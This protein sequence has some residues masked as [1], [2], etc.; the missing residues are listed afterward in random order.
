MTDNRMR[1]MN[2]TEC[3]DE[4][5]IGD[6]DPRL[7]DLLLKMDEIV[8]MR[9]AEAIEHMIDTTMRT[10]LEVEAVQIVQTIIPVVEIQ[11]EQEDDAGERRREM[12]S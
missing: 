4:T 7:A 1:K 3:E 10:H 11:E 9:K 6:V 5:R 8:I 12:A 2:L